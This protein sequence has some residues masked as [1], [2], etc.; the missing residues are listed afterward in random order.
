MAQ[1]QVD[2]TVYTMSTGQ[3]FA[4]SF[5]LLSINGQ[6]AGLLFG[7]EQFSACVGQ[8]IVK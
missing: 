3:R 4:R 2:D 6:C 1:V 5:K 7:D 8:Q